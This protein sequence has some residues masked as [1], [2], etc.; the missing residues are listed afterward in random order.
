[1]PIDLEPRYDTGTVARRYGVVP[2]TVQRWI[3]E[4]LLRAIRVTPR[5]PYYIPAS[6]ITEFEAKHTVNGV[7][8][9]AAS[10]SVLPPASNE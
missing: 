9:D 6:A 7:L 4:G 1:M 10:E 5:S 8:D 3:E 2:R